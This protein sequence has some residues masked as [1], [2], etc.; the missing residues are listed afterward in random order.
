MEMRGMLVWF[1]MV[2]ICGCAPRIDGFQRAAA[3]GN[4]SRLD[5]FLDRGTDVNVVDTIGWTALHQAAA[6]GHD[7]SVQL[8]LERGANVNAKTPA[9]QTPLHLAAA[10]G[11]DDSVRL[12]LAGNADVNAR[13]NAGATAYML[14]GGYPEISSALLAAGAQ[15]E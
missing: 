14:A 8:L 15:E 6:A 7:E 12:L 3:D 4:Q 10:R 9:G 2:M 5:R 1:W 11:H 13:T